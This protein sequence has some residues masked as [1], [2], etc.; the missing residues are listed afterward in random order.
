MV[1]IHRGVMGP[2]HPYEQMGH[3]ILILDML[4]NYHIHSEVTVIVVHQV[5]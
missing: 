3:L 1:D 4:L 5:G 2:G